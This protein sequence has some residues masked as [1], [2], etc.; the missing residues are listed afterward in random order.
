MRGAERPLDFWTEHIE[1]ALRSYGGAARVEQV[2]TWIETHVALTERERMRPASR[3][4]RPAF[5]LIVKG[6]L[7]RL[8]QDGRL[9]RPTPGTYALP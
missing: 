8:S 4:S 7:H 1:D 6:E 5:Q 9:R 2:L 3:R